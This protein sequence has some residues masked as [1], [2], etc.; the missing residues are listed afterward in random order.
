MKPFTYSRAATVLDAI[1]AIA[2]PHSKF[3]GGGTNLIDLMKM[4]VETPDRLVDIT[5]VPAHDWPTVRPGRRLSI[6][7]NPAK[8][9]TK[10]TTPTTVNNSPP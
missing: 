5:R 6:F 3:L 10:S 7:C 1:A 9:S 2:Q 4:G 8:T